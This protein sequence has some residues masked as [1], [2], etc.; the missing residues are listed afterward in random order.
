MER[1]G[2]RDGEKQTRR[3]ALGETWREGEMI[4]KSVRDGVDKRW[5]VEG[6][7]VAGKGRE[8]D[9]TEREKGSRMK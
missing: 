2:V 9:E 8:E 5:V 3:E 6:N 1:E 7:E 4:K